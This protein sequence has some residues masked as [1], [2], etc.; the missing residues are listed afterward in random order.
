VRILVPMMIVRLLCG[1][2][3]RALGVDEVTWGPAG[4]DLTVRS[5]A[6][7]AR[8]V[9]VA[10]RLR[11]LWWMPVLAPLFRV[12]A[13]AGRLCW[14]PHPAGSLFSLD[15]LWWRLGRPNEI[16]Q[17]CLPVRADSAVAFGVRVT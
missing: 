17:A 11:I 16:A 4:F 10:A 6:G 13:H 8:I 9:P 7:G 2:R 5:S 12:S 1:P 15:A 3:D 14:R